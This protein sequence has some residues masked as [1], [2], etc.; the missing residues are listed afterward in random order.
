MYIYTELIYIY[1]YK[2]HDNFLIKGTVNIYIYAYIY[3]N[4][5]GLL[6]DNFGYNNA[7]LWQ[8]EQVKSIPERNW[9]I[10][11]IKTLLKYAT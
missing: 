1:I 2:D 11:A 10:I 7:L 9:S 5:Y 8:T 3:I 6:P 4:I